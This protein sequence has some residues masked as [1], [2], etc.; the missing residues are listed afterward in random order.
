[1]KVRDIGDLLSTCS[2]AIIASGK[3]VTQL[4]KDTGISAPTLS[5]IRTGSVNGIQA[6]TV[7]TLLRETGW[8]MEI[9]RR[10]AGDRT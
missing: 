5:H 6:A 1:M 3:S 4:A 8:V 2:T 7:I 9:R 10:K